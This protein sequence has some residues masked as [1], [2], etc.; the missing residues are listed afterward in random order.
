METLREGQG[1]MLRDIFNNGY[2]KQ[3]Q[4][5]NDDGDDNKL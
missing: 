5:D 4:D 1:L 2:S 3:L